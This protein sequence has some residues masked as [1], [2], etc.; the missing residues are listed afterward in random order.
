MRVTAAEKHMQTEEGELKVTWHVF[1][2]K[3]SYG[4]EFKQEISYDC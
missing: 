1:S 2:Q 4:D 3:R